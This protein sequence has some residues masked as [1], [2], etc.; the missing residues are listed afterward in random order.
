VSIGRAP[1]VAAKL[2]SIRSG[3]P[4]YITSDVFD[5]LAKSSKYG[6]ETNDELMWSREVRAV[7]GESMILYRS[8]WWW[9]S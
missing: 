5:N 7:G 4:S 1:N 2:S 9:E 8:K 6:G 3:Y